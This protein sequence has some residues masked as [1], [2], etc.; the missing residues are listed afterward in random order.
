MND[1]TNWTTY[2]SAVPVFHP[3]YG[4]FMLEST[5]GEPYNG[6][7]ND[8]LSVECNMRFRLVYAVTLSSK[9][10]CLINVVP[11]HSL[12]TCDG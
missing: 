10:T 2:N 8:L 6:S 9:A 12:Q 7:V 4:R 3:E 5:P 1:K 11:M